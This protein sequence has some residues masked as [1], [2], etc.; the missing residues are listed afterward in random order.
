VIEKNNTSENRAAS[1]QT[2]LESALDWVSNSS[3]VEVSGNQRLAK[4]LRTSIYQVRRLKAAA[5]AKMCIGIYGPSQ[6]GKSYLVSALAREPG[7]RLVAM[8]GGREVDFIETINPEGGKESTGLVSRFTTDRSNTPPNFPIELKLLSELDLIKLFVNSYVNDILPDEDDDLERHQN[9]AQTI[10]SQLDAMPRG[11]SPLTLEDVY[12]LEDYCNGRFLS[13][14][15]IQALK[16]T[17]F[18]SRASELLPVL[19]STG[20]MRLVQLLWEDLPSYSSLFVE[21]AAE[22]DRLSHA[23]RVFAAPEAL[24][25]TDANTWMR[26]DNSII[27][28]ATLEK[29]SDSISHKVLVSV[30]VSSQVTISLQSLCSLTSELVIP[31][32]D[33]PHSIFDRVDLLDFPGARSRKAHPKSDRALGEKD[34]QIN[35]FLRGKVAYLFDKYSADLELTSMVLC[36]GP[37]NQEV[38]GLDAMIEDWV[39]ASHGPK[40][41]SREK[42]QT[43]LFVVLSKFDQ[44]FA[45]GAGKSLD[46]SRWSTRL[47]ASLINSFGAHA[48]R[49]N[50]VKKWTNN[51]SFNNVFWLR[52][53]NADQSGLI[54]YAG[55]PGSSEEIGYSV[56]KLNVIETLKSTFLSNNLVQQHFS[57]PSMAW[58]S[59]MSLN[60]GGASYLLKRLDES[61]TNNLKLVQ[62]D[63]RL[64]RILIDRKA[65]L[66][67]YHTSS[68][69]DTLEVDK[70]DFVKN[71][72]K[73]IALQVSKQRLG[74]FIGSLLVSDVDS[75]TTFKRAMLEFERSK[76]AKRH[77]E[78]VGMSRPFTVDAQLADDL[79]LESF[80]MPKEDGDPLPVSQETFPLYFIRCF[81]DDW[82]TRCIEVFSAVNTADYLLTD[83]ELS[84]RLLSELEIAARREGLVAWLVDYVE[85][86]HQYKSDD[87]RTWIWRQTAAVTASFNAFLAQGGLVLKDTAPIIA[88]GLNGKQRH[89]FKSPIE[90]N[91]DPVVAEIQ[92]DFSRDYLLDWVVALQHSVCANAPFQAGLQTDA[93]S[94]RQLGKILE[95]LK[96][97]LIVEASSHAT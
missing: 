79:G 14:L 16:K 84:V 96:S 56:R 95:D 38:V 70:R 52:N 83:R 28:V 81:F 61:C 31:M 44:E 85:K 92:P 36:L 82:R 49:T 80:D 43:S 18:W 6:S 68:D 35:N 59:G 90:A 65:D 64:S 25:N 34:V 23:T 58:D 54:E 19:G 3:E 15:R 46:G 33:K 62:I 71:I 75:F 76:H 77:V 32:R 87:R 12:D 5:S 66:A 39:V 17:D 97:I 22:L 40:P 55:T 13:N 30:S 1:A 2:I 72:T 21:L 47:Q 93:E 86:N 69:L 10:L 57:D 74:E 94:S 91:S 42:I 37:S 89:L 4:G 8:L 50:W 78:P 29:T 88:T 60:D 53:P 11:S 63:Q 51:S 27:N 73:V 24:F 26:S 45:E 9:Q 41:E 7:K 67:K 48:H 20:R